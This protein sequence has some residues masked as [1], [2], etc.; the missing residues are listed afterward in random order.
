M[1]HGLE[2]TVPPKV[3][4]EKRTSGSEL[5]IRADVGQIRELISALVANAS[6]AL[7]G[8]QGIITVSVGTVEASREFLSN[9]LLGE[10]LPAGS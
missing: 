10:E 1:T 8:Q 9:C 3:I 4:F 2:Q 5:P 6:D 7:V